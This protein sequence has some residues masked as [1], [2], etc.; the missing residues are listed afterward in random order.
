MEDS[1]L[2]NNMHL[3]E[4]IKQK[5]YEKIIY[6]IR[7]HWVTYIPTIFLFFILALVP[8]AVG[9]ILNQTSASLLTEPY[10]RAFFMLVFSVYELSIALF[11]FASFIMYYLDM[12]IITNDRLVQIQQRNLFSRSISELDLFK[13]QDSTSEVHGAVATIFSYGKLSIQTAGEQ[14]N[15]MFEAVPNVHTIRRELMHLAEEDRKFHV[16]APKPTEL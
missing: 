2:L 5:P 12:L 4:I 3:N 6:V 16:N 1:S 15:F 8:I 7:R 13:I 14:K 9:Y 11:F 10:S